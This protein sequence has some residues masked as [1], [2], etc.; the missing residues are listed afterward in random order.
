MQAGPW[1][2]APNDHI[3]IGF[4]GLLEEDCT[5]SGFLSSDAEADLVPK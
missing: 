1:P 5:F 2:D 3:T 4:K